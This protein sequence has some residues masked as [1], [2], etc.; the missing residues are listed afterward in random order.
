VSVTVIILKYHCPD[1]NPGYQ[2]L[3]SVSR[4]AKVLPTLEQ[5]NPDT[6]TA[7]LSGFKN[8]I[9]SKA[10]LVSSPQGFC[11]TTNYEQKNF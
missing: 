4:L 1:Q 2:T 9:G 3:K 6:V 8:S 10:L 5:E 7:R 11:F